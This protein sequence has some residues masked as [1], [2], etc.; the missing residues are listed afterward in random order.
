MAREKPAASPDT[1]GSLAW[2]HARRR[3]SPLRPLRP[4]SGWLD[5]ARAGVHPRRQAG[6]SLSAACSCQD[7][8]RLPRPTSIRNRRPLP[9]SRPAVC[10]NSRISG[11]SC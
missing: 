9:V 11:R 3:A 7:K 5:Q 4:L 6:S 8:R 2:P 10:T 1:T